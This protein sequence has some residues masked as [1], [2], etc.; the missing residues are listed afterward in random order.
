MK[1]AYYP[2][3]NALNMTRELNYSTYK[4]AE[5]LGIELVELKAAACCGAGV[6]NSGDP[7]LN[8]AWNARTFAMAEKD[9]LDIITSCNTCLL[10]LSKDNKILRES[11]EF[12]SRINGILGEVGARYNVS[13]QYKGTIKVKHL[14][15]ML[16]R[17]YPLEKLKKLANGGLKGLRVAAF[18]GCHILR[19]KEILEFDNPD[20]PSSLK[21]LI[22]AL[23][24]EYVKHSREKE[25][26]GFHINLED[27]SSI[28]KMVGFAV[29][30]AMEKGAECMVTP[31]SLCHVNLDIFQ[32]DAGKCIKADLG[33][34]ILHVPQL[35]GLAIGMKPKELKLSR[36]I[37]STK[38]L[39]KRFR[40]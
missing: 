29:K 12:L 38:E 23:G 9:G 3:C 19:P 10:Y 31:C 28:H 18:Y 30:E 13:L 32:P 27:E 14:L 17:D 5:R 21:D 36:H 6:I 22:G 20:Y 16:L 2:G 4:L 8:L 7:D 37:V 35:V 33:L 39:S 24:G 11:P 1:Y 15:W 40:D 26:C 34:P 25:C